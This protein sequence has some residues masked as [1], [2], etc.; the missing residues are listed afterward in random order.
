MRGVNSVLRTIKYSSVVAAYL[1]IK[2]IGKII[3]SFGA[4][5]LFTW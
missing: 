4:A 5:L 1:F 2:Y 3:I